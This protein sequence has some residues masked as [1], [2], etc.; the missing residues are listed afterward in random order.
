VGE[1]T[2]AYNLLTKNVNVRE[3]HILILAINNIYHWSGNEITFG[4][5]DAAW[6][7][8]IIRSKVPPSFLKCGLL[9]YNLDTKE[10]K[11][12]IILSYYNKWY[13][14]NSDDPDYNY[15]FNHSQ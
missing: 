8:D 10:W 14:A 6:G 7:F 2:C 15:P 3:Y 5:G 1:Y 4:L 9:I 13:I 11:E 12:F